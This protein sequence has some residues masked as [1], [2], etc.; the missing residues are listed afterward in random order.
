[1]NIDSVLKPY[2]DEQPKNI[3]M[4]STERKIERIPNIIDPTTGM[5]TDEFQE[6]YDKVVDA[7][8]SNDSSKLYEL[9]DKVMIYD[10]FKTAL[11]SFSKE[12]NKVVSLP[13]SNR[14]IDIELNLNRFQEKHRNLIGGFFV[15]TYTL[16]PNPYIGIKSDSLQLE[17]KYAELLFTYKLG[18]FRLL[19]TFSPFI[20]VK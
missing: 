9:S 14:G 15:I 17:Q 2:E 10:D 8:T 12:I 4:I 13:I 3:S 1:M 7:I 11:D 16:Q 5:V 18:E 19:S 20:D 6:F